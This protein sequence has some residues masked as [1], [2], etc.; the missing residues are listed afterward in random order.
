MAAYRRPFASPARPTLTWPREIA[1]EGDP[2]NV[3]AIV[4]ANANWLVASSVP[5][6]LRA[7]RDPRRRRGS[8]PCPQVASADQGDSRGGPFRPGRFAGRDRP[9]RRRLD[10]YVGLT[11][12]CTA[13]LLGMLPRVGWASCRDTRPIAMACMGR[14]YA[15]IAGAAVSACDDSHG[16]KIRSTLSG[17]MC[18]RASVA[19]WSSYRSNGIISH[20]RAISLSLNKSVFDQRIAQTVG[21]FSVEEPIEF[22]GPYSQVRPDQRKPSFLDHQP[23]GP[24]WLI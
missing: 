6:L 18:S 24:V 8:R 12:L 3:S 7:R 23:C 9:R 20:R 4:A 10:S 13:T 22:R 21:L 19:E 17:W 5:N 14:R 15:A 16:G 1:I 2:A 11:G